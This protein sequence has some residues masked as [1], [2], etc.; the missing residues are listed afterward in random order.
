[1]IDVIVVAGGSGRRFGAKKQW[2]SLL[3]RP[4]VAY[5]LSIFEHHSL[6]SSIYLGVPKGDLAYAEG[7]LKLYAPSKGKRV[8][9]GGTERHETVERGLPFVESPFVAVHDAVRPLLSPFLLDKLFELLNSSDAWGVVPAVSLKD[10]VKEVEGRTVVRTLDRDRLKAVQTP[11]LFKTELLKRAYNEV[12]DRIGVTDDASLVERAGGRVLWVEGE[13]FNIKITT[14]E[15]FFLIER[16]MGS[17]RVGFGYDIHKTGEG[18]GFYLGG[19]WIP[20][21]FSLLGHSDA[22][23]LIHAVVDAILGASGLGDIGELFPDTDERFKGV[24]S[25][26]FLEE[27]LA[28]VKQRGLSVVSLDV[29]VVAERPRLSPYRSAIRQSL[30]EILGVPGE[31]VN[32]KAKTKEGMDST[33]EGK[34]VEAFAVVLLAEGGML[35]TG[36]R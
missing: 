7:I 25:T 6:V 20:A 22:D 35:W 4:V 2:L 1:M 33:G 5:A 19:V 26:Y 21:D 15:D 36:R 9:Q 23:V 27:V 14:K 13:P 24:R 29:T 3:G 18:K 28:K 8:Y 11:Q 16:I 17:Y 34:A 32:V 31:A 12:K 30:A 10:T